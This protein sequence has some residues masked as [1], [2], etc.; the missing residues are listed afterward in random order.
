MMVIFLYSAVAI[1]SLLALYVGMIIWN[2]IMPLFGL[3]ELSYLQF[4]GLYLLF[5][6]FI[7]PL[8]WRKNNES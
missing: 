5:N 1:L 6:L 4:L 7:H 3:P 8:Y 2:N